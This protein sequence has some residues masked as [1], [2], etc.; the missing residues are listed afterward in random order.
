ME[1]S[2][3]YQLSY[4]TTRPY[5]RCL[6]F[7][8]MLYSIVNNGNILTDGVNER[9]HLEKKYNELQFFLN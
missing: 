8:V 4:R 5:L 7:F 1:N 9:K 3:R 2:S 6:M